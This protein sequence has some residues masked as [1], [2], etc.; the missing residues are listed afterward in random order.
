MDTGTN[1]F[2]QVEIL[3]IILGIIASPLHLVYTTNI[4]EIRNMIFMEI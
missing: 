4:D 1:I 3:P 2:E